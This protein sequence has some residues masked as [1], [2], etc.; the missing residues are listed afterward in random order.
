MKKY[1]FLLLTV[2]VC[3]SIFAQAPESFNYQAVVRDAG[4]VALVNHSVGIQISILQGTLP[5]TAV[6]I[7]TFASSTNSIGVINLAVGTG[8]VQNGSI[9]SID[10]SN[11]PYYMNVAIDVDGGTTYADMGTVELLSVPFALYAKT[12]GNAFSGDYNDLTNKPT[13]GGDATGTLNAN[14]VVKIQGM[15]VSS[16]IPANGQ[17]LKWNNSTSTWEPADDEL[18]AAGT[19]DGVVNG[20]SVTGTSSKTLT[21]IRSNGLG[22]ITAVFTDMVDDADADP[23]NEIQNLSLSGNNL[24]ISGGNMVTLPST[25]YTSG[26]GISVSGSTISNTAPDQTVTLTGTGATTVSGTYPSFTINSTDNNTTYTAGTGI[27]INGSNQIVNTA[28]NQVV[29]LTGTGSTTVSG[30]YPSFTINSTDANTVYT[31]GSGLSLTGTTFANTAPDQT[32]TIS[33]SGATTVTGTYPNFSISSTD[34]NTTYLAGT[35]MTLSGTTFNSAWTTSGA[36]LYNNNAGFVGIGHSSPINPLHV[37]VP[38]AASSVRIGSSS[39]YVDNKL[40]FGDGSFAFIGEDAVDDRLMIKGGSLVISAA[41]SIGAAG[42]VLTSNGTTASWQNN[43]VAGMWAVNG[44]HIYSNN[45]GN[46]GVGIN[47]PNARLTIKGNSTAAATEPLFEIKNRTGQTVFV[48]YED[49]VRI[50]VDDDPA[51][52]NK[53]T[54][55]VSGRNSSKA[56]TNNYLW[57]TPDSSRIYTGNANAGFG[58]RNINGTSLESYMNLTPYNYFIGH[59]SGTHITIDIPTE[60]GIYNSTLGYEAGMSLTQGTSNVFLGYQ[61]GRDQTSGW[62]NVAVG[63]GAG[64]NTNTTYTTFLG[65]NS[66][67]YAAGDDNVY[68]GY[69]AGRLSASND[70]FASVIIGSE[71]GWN[72][73]GSGNTVVGSGAGRNNIASPVSRNQNIFIGQGA[74]AYTS[75]WG[76]VDNNICIGYD[77][78][79]GAGVTGSN[80]LFIENLGDVTNPLIHGNFSTNRIAFHSKT[81]LYP[82]Q[83]GVWGSSVNGNGAYLSGGGVWN[84]GSSRL[85]K[86]RFTQLNATDILNKIANMDLKGWYYKETQEYHIGPFAEDFY[87]AFGCGD[88]NV[89]ED[90]GK[91]VAPSDVAGVSL[92]AIQQLIQQNKD[93]LKIIEDQQ[94][95]IE[96][97]ESKIK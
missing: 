38:A 31:A 64:T 54:F 6:Y 42:Q 55:A 52:S 62:S 36:N 47:V 28:P 80:Q 17:I 48:V 19:T 8:I 15:D 18:G 70:N 74:G 5:G 82:F 61:A 50:Y 14:T 10:W 12:A 51:K 69:N 33:G 95:R 94:K 43:S 58:V 89:K 86:D 46:V 83:V 3:N 60:Q 4:G 84:T 87:E 34:N 67:A 81:T 76:L 23:T 91:Y 45:T 29:S 24:S 35:G 7:E 39:F 11:G 1:L 72:S 97:L 2:F 92:F 21:L 73:F 71:T 16:N 49:S 26:T 44:T 85:I 65:C 30:T 40:Y 53:G 32:V 22:D 66:G 9:T 59:N 77:A 41:G 68:V 56:F 25:N 93:L 37:Y 88:Q 96:S 78:G 63:S 57:V 20:A 75:A 27:S 79:N 13:L 90:L